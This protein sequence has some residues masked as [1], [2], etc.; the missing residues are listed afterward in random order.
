MPFGDRSRSLKARI[1][2]PPGKISNAIIGRDVAIAPDVHLF[3]LARLVAQNR[4]LPARARRSPASARTAA[5][6][7]RA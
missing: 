1:R 7:T 2:P 5:R 3:N 4:A 6:E